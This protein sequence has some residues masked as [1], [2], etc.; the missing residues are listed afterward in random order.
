MLEV[1]P[2]HKRLDDDA[3]ENVKPLKR[4]AAFAASWEY[5]TV[6]G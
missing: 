6:Q 2:T 3:T 4:K 5:V 1:C